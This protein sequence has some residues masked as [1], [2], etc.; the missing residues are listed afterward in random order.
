MT[1][2]K[3]VSIK[4]IPCI[5]IRIKSTYTGVDYFH[6]K[7]FK[8]PGPA[9]KHWATYRSLEMV[10]KRAAMGAFR[11]FEE[12]YELQRKLEKKLARRAKPVFEHLLAST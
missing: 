10:E 3:V 6:T 7:Q 1:K 5:E 8:T 9:A 2:D 11:N 4:M 12:R